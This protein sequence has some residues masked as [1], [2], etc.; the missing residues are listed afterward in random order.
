M[1]LNLYKVN[2]DGTSRSLITMNQID[3]CRMIEKDTYFL[4]LLRQILNVPQHCPIK[5]V[6]NYANQKF[7][8]Q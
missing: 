6:G 3:V 4:P 5:K 2:S 1:T 7:S 8:P